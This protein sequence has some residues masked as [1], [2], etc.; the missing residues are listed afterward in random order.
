[1]NRFT[2]M[3]IEVAVISITKSVHNHYHH[4]VHGIKI[5]QLFHPQRVWFIVFTL[6]RW[7]KST[8]FG[9][10]ICLLTNLNCTLN[11]LYFVMFV[12]V[13]KIRHKLST[14]CLLLFI[15]SS[16]ISSNCADLLSKNWY[17]EGKLR[18]NNLFSTWIS[19]NHIHHVNTRAILSNGT[20]K[21]TSDLIYEWQL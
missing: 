13:I 18:T 6:F 11:M 16:L 15:F 3:I 8:W 19:I 2:E 14:L 10:F 5:Y 20:I 4:I 17:E 12:V 7:V 9:W 21:F 1:M